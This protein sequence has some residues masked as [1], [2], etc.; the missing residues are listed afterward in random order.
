MNI[1]LLYFTGTY[2]TRFVTSKL[3]ESLEAEG[4]TVT[5]YE[6]DPANEECLDFS[7]YDIVGLGSPIYGFAA[8]WPFLRFIR[9]QKFPEGK[10][11]FIYK[12]SGECY[13]E[14]DAS[15][16]YVLRKL[17]HDKARIENEYHFLM[18]YNIHFR[19]DD[20]LVREMF[21]MDRKLMRILVHEVLH[22]VPNLKPYKLWPRVVASVVSCPQYIA[23][24][25]NSFLYRVDMSKC[26][27]CGLCIKN[28]P[29]HNIYKDKNGNIRF[30][31]DCQ[32]CMRC[33]LFCPKDAFYIGFLDDWGW[34][35]N[36]AYN[37]KKIEQLPL[38]E[39]QIINKNTTGFFDCFIEKYDVVNRRYNELFND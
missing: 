9:K 13:H 15:H 14:N 25:V 28:C 6:I 3:R 11:L 18:P 29:K 38:P 31:H 23:G 35:V 24:D 17:R 16:K 36:G 27:D 39:P 26:I 37:F 4:C 7:P 20:Y 12:N 1:L 10:R 30:H 22:E 8:P 19:Y 21:E 32:M 33:S 5:T 2:N 34:R